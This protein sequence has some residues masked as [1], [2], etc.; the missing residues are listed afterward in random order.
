MSQPQPVNGITIL[1]DVFD[2]EEYEYI[3]SYCENVSYAYGE[4]D[5]EDG[6]V[7]G[8]VH[9]VLD[10]NNINSGAI[11]LYKLFEN[12]LIQCFPDVRDREPY[13]MYIN[14]FAN[15]ENPYFHEDSPGDP[16]ITF[17][18]YPTINWQLNDGGETQFFIDGHF[19]GVAPKP[20]RL[21]AFDALLTH[22][23]T[24]FRDRHRFSVAIKYFLD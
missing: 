6:P 17:L 9:E 19:Y 21:V 15:S 12:K 18:Y 5:T 8:L 14:C 10:V 24:T 11:E 4:T 1:D 7:T 13:R 23:A 3:R 22:R 16:G 2:K 20:N